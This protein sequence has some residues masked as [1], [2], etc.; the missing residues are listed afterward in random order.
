MTQPP[1]AY[2]LAM[3]VTRGLLAATVGTLAMDAVWFARY[4]GAGGE[5]GFL[6]WEFSV[7]LDSW[8][9]ASAPAHVGKLL[10]ETVCQRELPARYAAVTNNV[11]HWAY[12]AGW[13]GLLG[14]SI[15]SLCAARLRQ[16][17]LLGVLVWLASYVILPIAGS[18]RPIWTYDVK[19]L[20]DDLSAHL[21]Y[22]T[23]VGVVLRVARAR[24][25]R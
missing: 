4:R 14:A 20:W 11:M 13:G 15:G 19:T 18:Y 24:S 2:A 3:A 21:A 25:C 7:G 23:S 12:G 8:D 22:G 10:Y 1:R 5:S 16:G 6:V 17:P 9:K